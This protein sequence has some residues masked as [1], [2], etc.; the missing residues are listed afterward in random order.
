MVAL[1]TGMAKAAGL[2][3]R[4]W[5]AGVLLLALTGAPQAH[6]AVAVNITA[7]PNNS[8]Y[9]APGNITLN[10]TASATPPRAR[11]RASP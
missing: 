1:G 8:V 7:P 5:V 10:A 2:F 4:A 9:T 6:A 3:S 11:R